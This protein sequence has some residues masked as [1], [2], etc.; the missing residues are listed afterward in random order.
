MVSRQSGTTSIG[1]LA[2]AQNLTNMVHTYQN[3]VMSSPS[4][5]L[6]TRLLVEPKLLVSFAAF[7]SNVFALFCFVGRGGRPVTPDR[8]RPPQ[9]GT[10]LFTHLQLDTP[11]ITCQSSLV[12]LYKI[13]KRAQ[14]DRPLDRL[15]TGSFRRE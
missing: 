11:L 12:R 10:Y 1:M 3:N 14:P 8:F 15:G 9:R 5:G 2:S 6:P 13:Y 4:S 7:C